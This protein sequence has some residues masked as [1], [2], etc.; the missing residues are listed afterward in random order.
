LLTPEFEAE[1]DAKRKAEQSLE[2]SANQEAEAAREALLG[3]GERPSVANEAAKAAKADFFAKHTAHDG[4]D[5]GL[6]SGDDYITR[7]HLVEG[8]SNVAKAIGRVADASANA[9]VNSV[10]SSDGYV[11]NSDSIETARAAA[12]DAAHE[13][14]RNE[15]TEEF[16]QRLVGDSEI[17]DRFMLRTTP[18]PPPEDDHL[19]KAQAD[20]EAEVAKGLEELLSDEEHGS[21]TVRPQESARTDQADQEVTQ[22]VP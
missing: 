3:I 2:A 12:V 17:G 20:V 21:G 5:E 22:Q 19:A 15:V 14:H 16:N 7:T 4:V 11:L 1:L 13:V 18:P 10:T 9:A 8:A 6:A